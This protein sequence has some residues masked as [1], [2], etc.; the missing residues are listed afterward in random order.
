M[1]KP[2]QERLEAHPELINHVE[3]LLDIAEDV[4]GTLKKADDA[5]IKIVENMRKLG[6]SLLAD[7]AIHQED[8]SSN[9]WKQINPDA[10]GHGKKKSIGKQLMAE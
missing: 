5:E 10:I 3:A 8:K 7:W 2:L 6:H 9:E 4:N 1:K